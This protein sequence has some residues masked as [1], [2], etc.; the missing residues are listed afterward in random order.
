MKKHM[1]MFLLA[2][3][4]V[5]TLL[6]STVMYQLEFTEFALVKRFGKTVTSL[7]GATDAGLHFKWPWP[8]ERCVKYDAR[9]NVFEDAYGQLATF[10]DKN[11]MVTMYCAW[12]IKDATKFHRQIERKDK[13]ESSLRR[14]LRAEK[15]NVITQHRMSELVNTD[16]NAMQIAQ[17]EQEIL[18]PMQQRAD[19]DYGIEIVRVGIKSLG[20]TK[21]VS[22]Q[23]IANMKKDREKK[24]SSYESQ[25]K[26][27]ATAIRE[28]AKADSDLILAF[29]TRKAQDIR[30]EGA[31][32]SAQYYSMF[33]EEPQLSM[34]LRSLESLKKEL[35]SKSILILD[36][37]YNPAIDFFKNGPSPIGT[38]NSDKTDASKSE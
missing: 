28:R 11:I 32:A 3:L 33:N 27:I 10:D 9:T 18:V 16:P 1:G 8:I 35:N 22:N 5:A 21:S 13:A 17:I 23:V 25:G 37:S 26:A 14:L 2:L 4:V 34:F 31:R 24:V 19:E 29:A 36:S 15:K 38:R 20:L 12:R 7:D 6:A 30:S